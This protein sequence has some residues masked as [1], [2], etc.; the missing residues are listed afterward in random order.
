MAELPGYCPSCG[1]VFK[2]PNIVGGSGTMTVTMTGNA[3]TCPRCGRLARIGDGTYHVRN[4]KAEF[5]DGPPITKAVLAQ[6]E[7]IA[8]R[9]TAQEISPALAV[10][11][12]TRIDPRFGKLFERF[13]ALG[14]TAFAAFLAFLAYQIQEQQYDL[15]KTDSVTSTQFYEKALELLDR[16][17]SSL[18]N[19]QHNER[20][21]RQRDAP[22]AQKTPKK[23]V[24][25]KQPSKRRAEVNRERRAELKRRRMMFGPRRPGNGS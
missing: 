9:A 19:E 23:P 25:I 20:V 10:A 21:K 7:E 3:V 11:E 14:F 17:A 1:A 15:Q 13:L 8:R 2:L 6:L 16:Q 24:A 12:A 4:N 22:S 18:E 5:V